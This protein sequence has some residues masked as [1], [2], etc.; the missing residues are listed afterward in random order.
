LHREG[1]CPLCG[2]PIDVCTSHEETGPEFLASYTM[3]RATAA[4]LEQQRAMTDG[5]K[6]QIPDA[7]A[8][9]WTTTIRK[10]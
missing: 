3:C 5:G 7:P 8:Y 2:R 10:R 6:K 1:L 4:Q 9:L